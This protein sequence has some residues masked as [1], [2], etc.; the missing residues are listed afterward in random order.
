MIPF[1]WAD[2]EYNGEPFPWVDVE[3]RGKKYRVARALGHQ[4]GIITHFLVKTSR[5]GWR[6][7]H[8]LRA[9]GPK[10]LQMALAKRAGWEI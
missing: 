6:T 7:T 3:Y 10:L 1:T 8:S 9:I 2:V 5:G 4:G